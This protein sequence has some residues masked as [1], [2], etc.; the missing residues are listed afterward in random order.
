VSATLAARSITT[1]VF[2]RKPQGGHGGSAVT[3]ALAGRQSG[4]CLT[5]D[6][7]GAAIATCTG[8]ADQAW[9]YDAAG[10]LKGA[11]GYLTAGGS[12][13][14]ASAAAT[15]DGTQRWLLNGNG[16]IVNEA[17]GRCL[18]VS[19]QATADGSKVIVYSC[20]GGANEAWSR[21]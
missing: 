12:G 8:A 9:S 15:G 11:N 14:E 7:S 13:L 10:T 3:G 19:G 1:Y 21:Q 20:N 2:D 5:A 16:Q 17:S 6:A 4:K 18:D